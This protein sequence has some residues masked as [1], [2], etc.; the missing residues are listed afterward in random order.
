MTFQYEDVNDVAIRGLQHPN[1]LFDFLTTFIPRKLK[2][3]FQYCEYL[4]YNSP[5][6]FAALNKF[7]LYPVTNFIY[8]TESS[9]LK[10]NYKHL[11]EDVLKLKTIL[12]KTG[13]DRHVYGNSFTSIYFPFRR[14][15]TCSACGNRRNIKHVDY[16]FN[17]KNMEFHYN[18]VE[19]HQDVVG[20]VDDEKIRSADAINIIRWDPKNIDIVYNPITGESTYYYEIPVDLRG[21]VEK[22]DSELINTMP[23]P[24]LETISQKKIFQFAP[25]QVYHMK[26]DAPAGI[27]P[28]WGFPTL[29]STLKQFY[30]VAVLRKANEAIGL[31]HIV[32][33]RVLHPQQISGNADPVITIS[34]SN[35]MEEVKM[36][37]RQWRRDPLHLMFSPVALGVTNLGGQGRAL[38][39]TGEIKEA[40]ENIIASMGI[41]REFI[42]GGLSATGSGVT[43]RMLENQLLNYT[44]DLVQLGQWIADKVA[45][46]LGWRKIPIDL[47]PFKLVDDVQ[48]KGAM[49]NANQMTG[50][51]LL[52][53]TSM[54]NMFSKDLDEERKLRMQEQIDEFRFQHDLQKKLEEEQQTLADK[55]QA[56]AAHQGGPQYNVPEVMA[57]AEGLVQQLAGMDEG[58]R[59]SFL[60]SLQTEDPVMY[61]VVIQ[62]WEEQQTQEQAMVRQQMQQTMP[63]GPA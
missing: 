32:P 35:W 3:L 54:A 50:G 57:E 27:D 55:A 52:S 25:G 42:Y 14:F 16:K 20:D 62:R 51:Q 49:I 45:T 24:F 15:L 11:L 37:I 47:E 30:Y 29:T 46:Y 19:C 28:S 58:G 53:N 43:L 61:A 23:M 21:R 18:C 34:L 44:T 48:Q 13:I 7:A 39:V 5:Q 59:R 17:L 40:E 56:A 36:N 38:M 31:E 2:N 60:H 10:E 33:F 22:G 4:Y 12:V 63:G 41:P 1:P 26:A 6:I 8:N 9:K